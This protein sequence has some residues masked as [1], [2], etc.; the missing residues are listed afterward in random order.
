MKTK[1]RTNS[2]LEKKIQISTLE[3]ETYSNAK[4]SK[5]IFIFE[6]WAKAVRKRASDYLS[7]N[8]MVLKD[9]A[10]ND[11]TYLLKEE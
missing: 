8:N 4:T 10:G 7:N 3:Y 6:N 11:C 1:R 5:D 2:S 9:V